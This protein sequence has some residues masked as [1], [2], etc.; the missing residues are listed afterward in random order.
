MASVFQDPLLTDA[1]VGDNVALGLRF[2]GVN[3]ERAAPRVTEWLEQLGIAHL[4]SR[5]SRTLSGGEAQRTALARALV[6]EPEL[7]LLD[8]PFSALDQPTREAA[9]RGPRADPAAAA[10]RPRCWSPTIAARPRRSGDR[11][12]VM[13]EGRLLQV[14]EAAHCSARR[15]R[16]RSRASSAS[17]PCWIAGSWRRDRARGARRRR[18]TIEVAQPAERRRVG[19]ALPAAGGRDAHHGRSRRRIPSGIASR[20]ACAWPRAGPHVR[21][22][23]DCG[24]P[25]V[26]LVTQ[27]SV[28]EMGLGA[29]QPGDRPLQ[30]HRAAPAPPRQALTA[31]RAREY[32][33]DTTLA[34]TGP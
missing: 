29:G 17:R 28:E 7:L 10:G 20:A 2:R 3:R 33:A 25:L 22:T 23:I 24:F 8:E 1:T 34:G 16:R 19:A 26:A 9:H 18:Q 21:V 13:L 12:A 30:G 4:A 5:Q 11:V 27:R 32:N 6:L 31:R 14:D 15:P